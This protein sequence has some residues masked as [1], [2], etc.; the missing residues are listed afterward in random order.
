MILSMAASITLSPSV[1]AQVV[2][3]PGTVIQTYAHINVFPNPVGVG[4][5]I[6][7][8]IFL[9]TPLETSGRPSNFTV[10]VV[11][12]TGSNITLGPYTGDT[13]GGTVAYYTPDQVGNYTFQL[14]YGGEKLG[15][16]ATGYGSLVNA[17]SNSLPETITVQQEPVLPG[18]AFPFTPLPT[19][20]WQTPVSAQNSANW[21]AIT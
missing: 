11:P 13:T 6:T 4:Q 1:L 7:L 8:G 14:F 5:Q 21:Y 17:P 20:W 12:P 2:P 3:S 16:A 18:A 9:S 19:Q 15:T 10:N